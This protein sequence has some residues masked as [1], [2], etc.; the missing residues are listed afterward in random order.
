VALYDAKGKCVVPFNSLK[1]GTTNALNRLKYIIKMIDSNA[2][3]DGQYVIKCKSF[4]KNAKIDDFPFTKKGQL[5]VVKNDVLAPAVNIEE[6]KQMIAEVERLKAENEILKSKVNEYLEDNDYE[7]DEDEEEEDDE[8]EDINEKNTSSLS[9][10]FL[11]AAIDCILSIANRYLDI[12]EREIKIAEN[13]SFR[14]K[15]ENTDS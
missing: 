10:S 7:Y 11:S 3:A 12:K 1:N 14:D 6:Y 15:K 4:G 13:A 9:Q 5:E 8:E 2:I